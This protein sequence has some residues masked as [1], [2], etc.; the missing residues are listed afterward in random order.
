[1]TADLR[2]HMLHCSS[3]YGCALV[4]TIPAVTHLSQKCCKFRQTYSWAFLQHRH[5]ATQR[6]SVSQAKQVQLCSQ[7]ALAY[8]QKT[9]VLALN[10]H[11]QCIQTKW[12]LSEL[13]CSIDALTSILFIPSIFLIK[14]KFSLCQSYCR[15]VE[16]LESNTFCAFWPKQS[17]DNG[18][19]NKDRKQGVGV[20]GMTGNKV[21]ELI[22]VS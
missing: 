6:A 16:D 7:P 2:W 1:M 14:V 3:S 13:K 15:G 8:S 11:H 17:F 4:L 19:L 18:S 21:K 9:D 5:P 20:I 12:R 22:L 10:A